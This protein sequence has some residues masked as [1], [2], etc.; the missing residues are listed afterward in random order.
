MGLSDKR[1]AGYTVC[2]FAEFCGG[3][4]LAEGA[5]QQKGRPNNTYLNMS[6]I[7]MKMLSKAQRIKPIKKRK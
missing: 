4:G 5:A 1:S 3:G 2:R 7:A 6:M